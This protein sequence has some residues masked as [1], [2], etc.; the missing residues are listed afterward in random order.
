MVRSH[1]SL[2]GEGGLDTSSA[3][4]NDS[5]AVSVPKVNFQVKGQTSAFTQ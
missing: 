5:L 4:E 3:L 2:D 1:N